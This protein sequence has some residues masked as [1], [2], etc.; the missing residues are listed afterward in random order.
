VLKLKSFAEARDWSMVPPCGF[1]PRSRLLRPR[2][3]SPKTRTHVTLLGPCFKTGR[4]RAFRL[5]HDGASPFGKMHRCASVRHGR[6]QRWPHCCAPAL[7]FHPRRRTD[8]DCHGPCRTRL[9]ERRKHRPGTLLL[10][11]CPLSNFKFFLQ[12]FLTSFHL[13]LT[14]LVRY[15]SLAHI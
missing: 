6:F 4:T 1:P 14:V 9:G 2:V 7:T 8:T 12:S 10:N 5:R 13:S 3:F 15:R 11:G